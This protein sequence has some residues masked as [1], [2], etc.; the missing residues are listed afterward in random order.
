MRG[1]LEICQ[2]QN[3][4]SSKSVLAGGRNTLQMKTAVKI[5]RG[6][7]FRSSQSCKLL[8]HW[9]ECKVASDK[10]GTLYNGKQIKKKLTLCVAM[11]YPAGTI[12][13]SAKAETLL[14][15]CIAHSLCYCSFEKWRKAWAASHS[16]FLGTVGADGIRGHGDSQR[17]RLVFGPFCQY[18]Q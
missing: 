1:W 17:I 5:S 3:F 7:S 11:V 14:D 10:H 15:S 6:L 16:G 8:L 4:D 13:P 12:C 2:L 18:C 9:S